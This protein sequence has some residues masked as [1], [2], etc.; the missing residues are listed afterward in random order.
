MEIAHQV[1][2]KLLFINAVK[3]SPD[4]PF[5]WAS[6]WKSPIYCDNRRILS[7][8]YIRDYIKSE[9]SNLIDQH[10]PD[11]E[12]IAGVATAG[13]AH[14]VLA[15]DLLKLNFVYV[16]SSQKDHGLGNQIEGFFHPGQRIVVVEDLISTGGSS[17]RACEALQA[18]GGVV[19]GVVAVFDYG[20]E[21]AKKSF[22]Q[23]GIPVYA[24]SHYEALLE[25]ALEK[26]MIHQEQLS[27]LQQWRQSPDTWGRG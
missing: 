18:A 24:L 11:V 16:R 6:G 2:E 7:F 25:V 21:Q 12:V 22:Q 17:M 26:G 3:L 5:T 1:A 23:A 8:P 27:V 9:L 10:F 4:K 15:A 20:F 13:I 14:G 19:K